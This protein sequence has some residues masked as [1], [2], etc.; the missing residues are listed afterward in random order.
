M[1]TALPFKKNRL[2]TMTLGVCAAVW[3]VAEEPNGVYQPPPTAWNPHA[4]PFSQPYPP[5]AAPPGQYPPGGANWGGSHWDNRYPGPKKTWI[6]PPPASP[7]P[8]Q[9]G[10]LQANNPAWSPPP[11]A[12]P[13]NRPWGAN[14]FANSPQMPG[15]RPPSSY[16]SNASPPPSTAAPEDNWWMQ[17]PMMVPPEPPQPPEPPEPPTY[18]GQPPM[19]SMPTMNSGMAV[20]PIGIYESAEQMLQGALPPPPPNLSSDLVGPPLWEVRDGNPEVPPQ[21][22]AVNNP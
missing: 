4:N 13:G 3:A 7:Q 22:P 2:F 20:T 17:P 14:P 15:Y 12:Y 21:P 8:A 9:P 5:M 19:P 10:S 16:S 11:P 1:F 6:D 18:P